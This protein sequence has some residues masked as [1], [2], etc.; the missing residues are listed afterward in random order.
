MHACLLD[1]IN[2]F[3]VYGNLSSWSKKGYKA[4]PICNEAMYIFTRHILTRHILTRH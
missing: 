1:I 2:D 4:C 3:S